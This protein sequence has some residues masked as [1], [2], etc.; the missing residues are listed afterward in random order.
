MDKPRLLDLFCGAGGAAKGYHDAGFDVVGVDIKPQPHYPFEF[1]QGDALDWLVTLANVSGFDFDVVH[2]SPPCQAYSTATRDHSKHPDLYAVTREHLIAS[3]KPY[4]IENVIGAPYDSGVVLCGSM[5]GLPIQRHRNFETS[6]LIMQ[7]Q[8]RHDLWTHRPYTIT[9]NGSKTAKE[10]KHSNHCA[11]HE[12][13]G[14]MGMPWA[15]WDEAKLAIPPAYTEY[16]GHQ[17]IEYLEANS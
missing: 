12:A 3:E 9:G 6:F 16:I 13:A 4:V 5:F 14:I 2:A 8:C 10:Y 1:Y 15:T 17:L 11:K 7:P